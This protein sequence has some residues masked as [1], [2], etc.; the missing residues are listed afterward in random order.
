MNVFPFFDLNESKSNA[1]YDNANQIIPGL[2]LGNFASSQDINFIKRNNITVIINCTKDL[3]FLRYPNI[4]KYRVPVHDNL[5]KDEII[6][7][8]G[9]ID[10]ILPIIDYHYQRKKVILIHCAAGMQ[11]SAIVMLSYLYHYQSND[12]GLAL[13]LIKSRR[14]IAFTPYMNFKYSFCKRFGYSACESLNNNI[15]GVSVK[16]AYETNN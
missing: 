9:W 1:T 10:K 14:P 12:A 7:M 4:Y 13:H 3:K 6:S 2:W 15:Y 11:R 8:I 5:E 16:G